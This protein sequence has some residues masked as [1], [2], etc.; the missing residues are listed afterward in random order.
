M[1]KDTYWLFHYSPG[2][3]EGALADIK[4]FALSGRYKI[5]Q[6]VKIKVGSKE[7]ESAARYYSF[8]WIRRVE[9]GIDGIIDNP[10]RVEEGYAYPRVGAGWGFE[11][12]KEFLVEVK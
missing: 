4:D 12:L 8:W 1:D 2:A 7:Y 11:F 5:H 6:T 10:M 3:I 9:K